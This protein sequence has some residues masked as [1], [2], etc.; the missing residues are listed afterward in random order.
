MK[1]APCNIKEM[2]GGWVLPW[3]LSGKESTCQRGR[4]GFTSSS[5]KIPLASEQLICVPQLLSPH[6]RARALRNKRSRQNERPVP[7]NKE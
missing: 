2:D 3:W 5:G 7:C 1:A 4:H 6:S